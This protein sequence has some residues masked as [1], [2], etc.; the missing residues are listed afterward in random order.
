MMVFFEVKF[1]MLV[2]NFGLYVLRQTVTI[3][4]ML[5]FALVVLYRIVSKFELVE[6]LKSLKFV[7]KICSI[8]CQNLISDFWTCGLTECDRCRLCF[9]WFCSNYMFF[10]ITC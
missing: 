4:L 8:L 1:L 7:L 10:K 6:I 9:L 2:K 3:K 5:S